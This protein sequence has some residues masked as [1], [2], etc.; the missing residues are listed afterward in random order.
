MRAKE[1]MKFPAVFLDSLICQVA[2][3][4]FRRGYQDCMRAPQNDPGSKKELET[5][6]I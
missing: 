6:S 1:S 2:L 3:C 5:I 4:G